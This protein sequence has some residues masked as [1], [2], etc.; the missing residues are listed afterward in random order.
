MT[1]E[2]IRTSNAPGAIG[3]YSQAK[4]SGALLFSSMQIPLDP[5]TGEMVGETAPEQARQCLA[6]IRS[7]VEAGG[8]SVGRIVKMMVY[9]TDMS[10]FG[11]VNETYAEF[12]S[13]E[14]PARGVVEVAALP[15]N[16][17]VAMEAVAHIE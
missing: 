4:V 7:L 15:K 10:Q 3:P 12:F 11:A 14:P 13:D 1:R 2:V 5:A 6:N 17:L 9:L 16:A 8:G